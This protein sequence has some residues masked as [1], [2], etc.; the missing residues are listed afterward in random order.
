VLDLTVEEP[1]IEDVIS[2]LYAGNRTV[3]PDV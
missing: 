3:M 2:Q 1:R